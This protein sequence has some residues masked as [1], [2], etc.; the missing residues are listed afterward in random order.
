MKKATRKKLVEWAITGVLLVLLVVVAD[1][2]F[3]ILYRLGLTSEP[4]RHPGQAPAAG[5]E[6]LE[7]QAV[8]KVEVAR[9][10]D[11]ITRGL[12]GRDSLAPDGG[13]YFVYP[14]AK[15]DVR[16]FY[17][18]NT[19]IPLSIAF[20][21]ADG[22]IATIKDMQPF[23]ETLVSSEVPVKDAL[24]MSQGW[25]AEHKIEVGDRAELAGDEV[26]FFRRAR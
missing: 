25:F 7:L 14:S 17:M 9:T 4:W 13:M 26:H 2:R 22:T 15:E 19:R 16:Y 3:N 12:M 5:A 6:R 8:A 21:R 18:K 24:E 1:Y 20:I 23:D 11:E 10:E